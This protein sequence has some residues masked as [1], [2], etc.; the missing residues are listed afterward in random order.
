MK[1]KIDEEKC[2]GC[3]IC[4]SLCPDIFEM[5]RHDLHHGVEDDIAKVKTPEPDDIECVKEAVE[6]CPGE[7]IILEE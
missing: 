6:S 7:A 2:T 4:E 1:V 5:V 3:G